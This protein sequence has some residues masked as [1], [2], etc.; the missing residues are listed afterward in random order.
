MW[1]AWVVAAIGLAA[2]LFMLS[3]LMALLREGAPSVCYWVVP[4]RREARGQGPLGTILGA[5]R[6]NYAEDDWR[7]P[8]CNRSEYC[9]ELLENENYAKEECSSGLI[10]L[11]VRPASA[12]LGWRSIRAGRPHVFHERRL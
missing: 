1:A 12:N 3:F 4:V 7:E 8:E 11:D 2:A 5:R 6:S 9:V 10:A